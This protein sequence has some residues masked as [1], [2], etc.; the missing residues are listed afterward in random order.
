MEEIV[1]R[2]VNSLG[3]AGI[4]PFEVKAELNRPD[5]Y[6]I[7][8]DVR[9]TRAPHLSQAEQEK[10]EIFLS[11]YCDEKGISYKQGM[12]EIMAV[13]LPLTR[14][15]VEDWIV[16]RMFAGFIEAV[17]P[18]MFQDGAFRP[19]QA[20]FHLFRLILVYH[21]PQIMNFLEQ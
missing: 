4:E 10:L 9:R 2:W 11:C 21:R 13:F 18:T 12:N 1:L 3:L 7:E 15:G 20:L 8:K 16:Y 19:I 14:H 17:L 5:Q 6:V